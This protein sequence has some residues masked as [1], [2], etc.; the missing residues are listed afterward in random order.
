[1]SLAE[2]RRVAR[3]LRGSRGRDDGRFSEHV[4][5]LWLMLHGWR[6]VGFR[7]K[8]RRAEVDLLAVKGGVLAVV[9]VKRRSTLDEATRAVGPEQRRRL[10]AAGRAIQANTPAYAA[11]SVRLDMVALAPGKL[12]R[13]IEGLDA[14]PRGRRP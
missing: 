13:H 8:T 14:A 3:R 11:L 10:G 2:T 7:L 12:P 1:M 5:A 9:E 4:A 6:V